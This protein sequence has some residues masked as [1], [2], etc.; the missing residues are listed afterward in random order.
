MKYINKRSYSFSIFKYRLGVFKL[1]I[2]LHSQDY[3]PRLISHYCGMTFSN[4][5]TIYA[6]KNTADDKYQTRDPLLVSR[7]LKPLCQQLT[8]PN[9]QAE[10]TFLMCLLCIEPFSSALRQLEPWTW[11]PDNWSPTT[12]PLFGWQYNASPK[13][14]VSWQLIPTLRYLGTTQL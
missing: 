11:S 10:R 6:P 4:F 14:L 8:Q 5:S 13:Q 12:C 7:P 3:F 9:F 2:T 1:A